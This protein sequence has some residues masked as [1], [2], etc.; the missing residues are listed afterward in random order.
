M[1][2][3]LSR[4][5]SYEMLLEPGGGRGGVL[6]KKI[7][8]G[9]YTPTSYVLDLFEWVLLSIDWVGLDVCEMRM[10]RAELTCEIREGQS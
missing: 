2:R 3:N 6:I 1:A 7:Q 4:I 10:G 9:L 5:N 8:Y